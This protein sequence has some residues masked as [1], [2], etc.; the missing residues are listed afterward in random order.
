MSN[1]KKQST[2]VSD[3][4]LVKVIGGAS[5]DSDPAPCCK[6]NGEPPAECQELTGNYGPDCKIA[7]PPGCPRA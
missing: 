2:R 7:A 3:D 4:D 1:D 6:T 5:A